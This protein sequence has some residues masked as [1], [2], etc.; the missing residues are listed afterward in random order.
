MKL[1]DKTKGSVSLNTQGRIYN[2]ACY[3]YGNENDCTD[4]NSSWWEKVKEAA[5]HIAVI[6]N[7]VDGNVKVGSNTLVET[8]SLG[9]ITTG[10]SGFTTIFFFWYIMRSNPY[11]WLLWSSQ[12][13]FKQGLCF[14]WLR[15]R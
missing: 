4:G 5:S 12:T 6:V 15:Y 7:P 14:N 10:E 13:L 11:W 8:G 9:E 1:N 2:Q 3:C